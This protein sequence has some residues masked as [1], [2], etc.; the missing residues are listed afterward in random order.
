MESACVHQTQIPG[1]SKLFCDYLYQFDS[2]KSF[3]SS[4]FSELNSLT[5]TARRLR[6]PE[7]RRERMVAALRTQNGP[8][9][10]LSL[11][12]QAGTVAVVT[13]QQVGLFSGPAY[14]VFKA[15]TAVK[16]TE[17]LRSQ[18]VNAVPVF[19]LATED[20]DL[21]EVDHAWV[22]D[23]EAQPSKVSVT[24]TVT[25]GGPVGRVELLELPISQ[26]REALAGLPFR[27]E[28]IEK[29]SAAYHPGATFGSAFR[30]LLQDI[31]KDFGLLY[32]DPLAPEVRAIAADFIKDI[33][34]RVPELVSALRERDKELIG[35]GYHAQV[36]VEEDTSLL[37]LLNEHKR[38]VI[39]W[40]DGRFVSREASYSASE[41][42]QIA[43][44]LSPNALL[45]PVMQDYLLPTASYVG[46]PAETAYL[47]QSQVLYNSLLGQMPVIFPRN[48]F[49]LLDTRTA[50]LLQRYGLH[51]C[52]IF[53]YQ[54]KVKSQIAAKLV[55]SD[56]AERFASLRSSL[57]FSLATLQS[58]LLHF[59]PTLESA[60][61][62]STSK[63]LYQLEKLEKKTARETLQR[64]ERASRDAAYVA[65]L[66]YPHRHLQER[67]YST[68]PFLAKHGLDLP[69]KLLKEAQLTCPDHM[70]R[71]I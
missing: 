43:E 20:H 1:A 5:D 51:V 19:W 68:V 45:R 56:L 50:K 15:L 25:N 32:L 66:V 63:I 2:V 57:A 61:R 52:D 14:T 30:A 3:Y 49:T 54:E 42:K 12:S 59:D 60:A 39:R 71:V 37:F 16:L 10:S 38:T 44:H 21:A 46:G 70:I 8:S 64:D 69:Q 53:D 35:A 24:N 28:V 23:R 33:I 31:L 36:L 47:A 29:V 34:D 13:G 65:N 7:S 11:L 41:L 4:H 27:D 40:K 6:Y 58:D 62:K 17:H 22:F 55:P 48:S 9:E 67:F 26:L 18:G